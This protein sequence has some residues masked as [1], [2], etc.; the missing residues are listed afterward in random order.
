M[1]SKRLYYMSRYSSSV[2]IRGTLI[3]AQNPEQFMYTRYCED[4]IYTMQEY[5]LKRSADG[6]DILQYVDRDCDYKILGK[7]IISIELGSFCFFPN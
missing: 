4:G 6:A 3:R 1:G 5:S 7:L 2:G